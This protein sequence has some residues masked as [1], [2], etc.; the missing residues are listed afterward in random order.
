MDFSVAADFSLRLKEL[1]GLYDNFGSRIDVR[2]ILQGDFHSYD[3]FFAYGHE[4]SAVSD[5]VLPAGT[6]LRS[7]C[8]GGWDLL[9]EVYGRICQYAQQHGLTLY[10]YAYEEGLNELSLPSREEYAT[11]VTVPCR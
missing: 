2:H 5:E 7:F 8:I 1:F 6:Y 4:G 9:G 11:M 3:C 10:G